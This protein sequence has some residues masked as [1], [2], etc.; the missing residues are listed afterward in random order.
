MI[1]V[2]SEAETHFRR[3]RISLRLRLRSLRKVCS[4]L[5][6]SART[7]ESGLIRKILKLIRMKGNS[8]S[9]A[10]NGIDG[11]IIRAELHADKTI[12][13]ANWNSTNQRRYE[14]Q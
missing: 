2:R 3:R 7:A 12:R 13:A 8:V 6:A 10:V 1:D 14:R 4:S 5:I 11:D 9:L